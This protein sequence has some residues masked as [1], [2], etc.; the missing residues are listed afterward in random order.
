M[1]NKKTEHNYIEILKESLD[2]KLLV[3]D[4]IIAFNREQEKIMK[5]DDFDY[6]RFNATIAGKDDCIEEIQELDRGF[7]SVYDRIKELFSANK[8]AYSEDIRMLQDKIRAIT[9]KSMDIQSQEARNKETFQ[10]RVVSSR[11]EIKTAK[12]ANKVA[13]NYYQ[14]MN[15]LNVVGSQ[16][17]DTKN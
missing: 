14:S 7:Q 15:K 2:K 13:A 8:E 1:Q 6:V 12:T 4:A 3:L 16:F 11:K 5:S 10:T 9:D 17:L